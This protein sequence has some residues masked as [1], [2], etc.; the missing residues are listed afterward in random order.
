MN[1]HSVSRWAL[2]AVTLAG[3]G[4]ALEVDERAERDREVGRAAAPGIEVS[5][6]D[7]LAVV[8]DLSRASVRLWAAAPNFAQTLR[9]ESAGDFT[10]V[11]DNVS[12]DAL[13][14]VQDSE[15]V[16]LSTTTLPTERPTRRRLRFMAPTGEIRLHVLSPPTPEPVVRFGLLSDIQGGMPRVGEVFARINREPALDF[17]LSTGDLG[18]RGSRDELERFERHLAELHVPFYSGIGN[19]EL[20]ESPPPFQDLFGRASSHFHFRGIAFSNIDSASATLAPPVMDW[21]EDWLEASRDRVHIV[22][23]HIPPV[24][25]V[26]VRNGSFGSRSEAHHVLARLA[27]GRVDLTLYGHIHSYYA[28]ENAGI[29]AYISGGG[30]AV[31]ERFDRVG[32]HFLVITADPARVRSVRLV[33]VDGAT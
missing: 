20:F 1:R 5:V 19:H 14:Q 26:G 27:E 17:V 30:G 32:R 33:R 21:L 31:P 11:L 22:F 29:P 16:A 13:V 15:G 23:M 25:P 28:F 7:G 10:V 3:W 2:L 6:D 18:S 8:R 9:F 4:C 24:D 12:S